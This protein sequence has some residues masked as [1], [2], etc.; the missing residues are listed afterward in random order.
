MYITAKNVIIEGLKAKSI[1]RILIEQ[2][3]KDKRLHEIIELASAQQIP[4]DNISRAELKRITNMSSPIAAETAE[5]T[6]AVFDIAS[7]IARGKSKSVRP[8]I[9]MLDGITDVHNFG[10]ILRS[11]HYF[12]ACGVVVPKDNSARVTDDVHRTSAGASYHIPVV[13]V[14]NLAQTL[15]VLKEEGFWTYAAAGDGDMP[16]TQAKFDSPTVIILGSEESGIRKKILE[17][18]DFRV[19]IEGYS[20]F[21]SLN[22]S[23]AAAVFIFAWRLKNP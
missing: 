11:A 17:H 12:G 20:G 18:A 19:R 1:R 15:D 22:V 6:D 4:V 13:T 23:T 7:L 2:G 9:L 14:V 10:A 5:N 8:L 3:Y 16:L 21:D